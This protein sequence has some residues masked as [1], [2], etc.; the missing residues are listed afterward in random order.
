MM[1][2]PDSNSELAIIIVSYLSFYGRFGVQLQICHHFIH[3][4]VSLPAVSQQG[5]QESLDSFPLFG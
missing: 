4:Y 3:L 5:R 2:N 1:A